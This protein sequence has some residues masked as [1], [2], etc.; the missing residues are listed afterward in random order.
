MLD[1]FSL[2]VILFLFYLLNE[3]A[4]IKVFISIAFKF[5][6]D[7]YSCQWAA[8]HLQMR[9]LGLERAITCVRQRI[10]VDNSLVT[11]Q[12]VGFVGPICMSSAP[13]ALS[14][15]PS[16][17]NAHTQSHAARDNIQWLINT[18]T[19]KPELENDNAWCEKGIFY[20]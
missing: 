5:F 18:N 7:T 13:P 2:C 4:L 17:Q 12:A 14:F 9:R 3:N 19:Y 6:S 16:A 8:V 11:M 1:K 15:C 20:A 10:L